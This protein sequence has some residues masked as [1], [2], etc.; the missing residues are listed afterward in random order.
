MNKIRD[1][2]RYKPANVWTIE[3]DASVYQ[4]LEVM[5]EKNV[6]ALLGVGK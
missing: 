2:L 5:A 6:G 1:L 4:A 3:P